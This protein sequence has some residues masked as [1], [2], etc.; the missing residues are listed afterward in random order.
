[1]YT[2]NDIARMAGYRQPRKIT[3]PFRFTHNLTKKVV[4][5]LK[6]VTETLPIEVSGT[7]YITPSASFDERFDVDVDQVIYKGMDVS[8][9]LDFAGAM[10]EI[11]EAAVAAVSEMFNGEKLSA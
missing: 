10:E 1:M 9:L 3:K 11:E 5:D 7:A 2:I 8:E 6:I 4:R